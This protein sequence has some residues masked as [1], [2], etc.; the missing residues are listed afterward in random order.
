M[1][2]QVSMSDPSGFRPVLFSEQL[3]RLSGI[4]TCGMK[5]VLT[6]KLVL[7]RSWETTVIF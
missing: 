1:V 3:V 4:S 2:V 6:D 5:G 7:L